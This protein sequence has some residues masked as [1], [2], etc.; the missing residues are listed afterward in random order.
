[1]M[2]QGV[3]Y[4]VSSEW[5]PKQIIKKNPVVVLYREGHLQDC[6]AYIPGK[7]GENWQNS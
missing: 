5:I 7:R 4:H 1:M 3:W 2:F 6:K